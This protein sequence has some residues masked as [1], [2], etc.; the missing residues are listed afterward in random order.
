MRVRPE[1]GDKFRGRI[2]YVVK[3]IE[4][5]GGVETRLLQYADMLT[6][7]G[8]S[9]AF[10]TERNRYAPLSKFPCYHLNFHARN[11]E[12][13]LIE[14]IVKTGADV[15]ELQVK[16]AKCLKIIQPGNVR[17]YCRLGCCVHGSIEGIDMEVLNSMDYRVL[18]SGT[19]F[20][21][22]YKGLAHHKVLPIAIG[23]NVS[24]W[25]YEGQRTALCVCRISRD[26]Y[27]QI[28]T[29][30]DYCRMRDIPFRIAGPKVSAST[31]GRL[32]KDYGLDS[33]HFIGR[34]DNTVEYLLAH[35]GEYLFVAG[36][37]QVILEAGSLGY[38]CY[39]TSDLGVANSTFLTQDNIHGNF[40]NNFTLAFKMDDGGALQEHE[41]NV[42]ALWKY[43]ISEDIK[44]KFD[45]RRRIDEYMDYV[46]V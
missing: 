28:T 20:H 8:F 23:S 4:S 3:R 43:N 22:D 25:R 34:L 11:F 27:R 37:G 10:V 29:F 24:G 14:L 5:C 40:G 17:R 41:L 36:V 44:E 16:K 18:I 19:L 26:K 21:V 6:R 31:V 12:K 7:H 35:A 30:V 39:L 1:D 33:T 45:I 9:V 15:V 2:L 46:F 42:D 13:S 38:P 32:K